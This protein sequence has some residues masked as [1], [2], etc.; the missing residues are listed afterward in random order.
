MIS[1]LIDS[2]GRDKF[3][4]TPP[5]NLTILSKF[6]P[7]IFKHNHFCLLIFGKRRE[8]NNQIFKK[9]QSFFILNQKSGKGTKFKEMLLEKVYQN[10]AKSLLRVT[11][12][13]GQIMTW[14]GWAWLHLSHLKKRTKK[15][16]IYYTSCHWATFDQIKPFGYISVCKGC[17]GTQM[18]H[19]GPPI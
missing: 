19:V 16:P 8:H 5:N 2:V 9:Y 12:E 17:L 1:L 10:L 4:I 6:T 11:R 3:E 13:V 15:R 18:V 7:Q 14:L